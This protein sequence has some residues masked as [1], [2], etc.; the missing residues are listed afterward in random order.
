MIHCR[1]YAE[2]HRTS[3]D[4]RPQDQLSNYAFEIPAFEPVDSFA[5]GRVPLLRLL[6]FQRLAYET[7]FKIMETIL[8]PRRNGH[9]IREGLWSLPSV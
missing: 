6:C 8:R 3:A 9:F 1:E 4:L 2:K 7:G 5:I